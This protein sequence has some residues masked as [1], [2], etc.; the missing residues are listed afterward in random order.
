MYWKQNIRIPALH[1][2]SAG[3]F[4]LLRFLNGV[5]LYP[6]DLQ[7]SQYVV[8]VESSSLVYQFEDL[9]RGLFFLW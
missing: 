5:A 3:G 6:R 4:L 2:G 9:I 1:M 8:S 7:V